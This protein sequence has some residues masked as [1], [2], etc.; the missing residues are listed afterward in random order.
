[1]LGHTKNW[2]HDEET[3]SQSVIDDLVT[4]HNLMEAE[5]KLTA[6][7]R[8]KMKA[9][10]YQGPYME[11]GKPNWTNIGRILVHNLLQVRFNFLH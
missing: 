10:G 11:A 6:K 9:L 4:Y 2:M 3:R 8:T 5:K 1:M 7:D